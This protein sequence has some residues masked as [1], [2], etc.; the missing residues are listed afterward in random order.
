MTNIEFKSRHERKHGR[1]LEKRGDNETTMTSAGSRQSGQL[2][3]NDTRNRT[4]ERTC[5]QKFTILTMEK[6]DQAN[7]S[8]WWYTHVGQYIKLTE[9]INLSTMTNSKEILP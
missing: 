8:M 3:P 2:L 5:T 1:K 7:D 9:D 6:Q 4:A